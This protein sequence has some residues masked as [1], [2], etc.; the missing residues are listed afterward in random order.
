MG[1]I[2]I[3]ITALAIFVIL[4]VVINHKTKQARKR[5][6]NLFREA[7]ARRINMQRDLRRWHREQRMAEYKAVLQQ[8]Q[9][10]PQP[11]NVLAIMTDPTLPNN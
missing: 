11:D 8:P 9:V 4:G 3:V 6:D 7:E 2:E 5:I 10:N 1:I